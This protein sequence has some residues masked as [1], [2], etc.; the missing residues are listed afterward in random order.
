MRWLVL[1]SLLPVAVLAAGIEYKAVSIA[2]AQGDIVADLLEAYHLTPTMVEAL[3]NGVP[4]TFVTRVVL[5]PDSSWPWQSAL[6]ERELRRTLRY[7][8]LAGSY[9]VQD[10]LTG[11]SRF[12]ATREA[13][14]VAL[15]D[16]KG[17]KILPASRLQHGKVYRVTIESW[18]DI[19]SLPVPLR[20]RAYLSPGWHLSSKTYQWR[21]EP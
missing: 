12:F 8:P 3:E 5:A 9:E 21:L 4:L 14:L 1:L 20:P 2:E 13:A 16:V 11:R 15:G 18:H 10:S 19:G 17:W 6:A 7:H